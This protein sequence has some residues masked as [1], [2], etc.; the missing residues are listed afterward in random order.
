M[1]M[2]LRQEM[3]LSEIHRALGPSVQTLSRWLQEE[4]VDL[5]PRQRNP[6]ASRSADEQSHI[7]A[8]IAKTKATKDG[9]KKGGR[10]RLPRMTV[11]CPVCD[12][13][14]ETRVDKPHVTCSQACGL[15]LANE[16]KIRLAQEAWEGS[17]EARCACGTLIP[18]ENRNEWK[19]CSTECRALYGKKRQADPTKQITFACGTCGKEQTRP[20]AY[21]STISGKRFCDRYCAAKHT[22]TVKHYVAREMDMVLDSGWEMLFAG[23]CYWH[24]VEIIRVER[25]LAVTTP[26]GS[27]YAPD[28]LVDGATWVEVKG[29]DDGSQHEGWGI[30]REQV[31]PLVVVDGPRLNLLRL[32]RPFEF[33]ATI[34]KA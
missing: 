33:L 6:N 4:K 7:N 20:R 32:A 25:S 13:S 22:R 23:L 9:A 15:W 11:T 12:T 28:F 34:T 16:R 17:P 10:K 18:Y 19:Y 14:F 26:D 30:W 31:G 29:H 5:Q 21:G 8:K 2:Y 24:K 3:S 27:T 1:D